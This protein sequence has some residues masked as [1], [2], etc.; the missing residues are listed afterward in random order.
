MEKFKKYLPYIV[1]ILGSVA[2]GTAAGLLSRSGMQAN[3]A[4]PQ[5]PLSPPSWVFPIAWTIFYVLMGLSAALVWAA[6]PKGNKSALFPFYLQL[7][8]N[9]LWPLLFFALHL[10]VAAFVLILALIAVVIW[11]CVAFFRVRPVAGWLQLPY[12]LW[13]CFAAYLNLANIL[14]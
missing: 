14:I 1:F 4:Q 7:A 5:P 12:A 10:E 3:M 11:M 8:L 9:F 13:L 2:V 6:H